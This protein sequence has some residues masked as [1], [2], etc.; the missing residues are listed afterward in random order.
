[1]RGAFIAAVIL[2]YSPTVG[3]QVS[4]TA[5][6]VLEPAIRAGLGEERPNLTLTD[7][8]TSARVRADVKARAD[9]FFL[10]IGTKEGLLDARDIGV[11]VAAAARLAVLLIAKA[12]DELA[13]VP[14]MPAAPSRAPPFA[15]IRVALSGGILFW[16]E[17]SS[18]RGMSDLVGLVELGSVLSAGLRVSLAGFCCGVSGDNVDADVWFIGGMAEVRARWRLG[19]LTP[20]VF[21]AL[22]V[23]QDTVRA[24]A[25]GVFEGQAAPETR[26]AV[27]VVGRLG[28]GLRV[29]LGRGWSVGA[30]GGVQMHGRDLSVSLPDVVAEGRRP[31]RRGVVVPF[32]QIGVSARVF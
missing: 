6:S 2:A 7:T 32:A 1:M 16:G 30:D 11:D 25:V 12:V 21:G 4:L 15:K 31:L 27:G 18:P 10:R 3:A 22:G 28:L 13:A 26:R 14:T 20:F 23:G 17:P 9:G 24:I 5:P 19:R 8:A 29:D